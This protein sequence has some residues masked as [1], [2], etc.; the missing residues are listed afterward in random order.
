MLLQRLREALFRTFP[1]LVVV[2]RDAAALLCV[3]AAAAAAAAGGCAV[4]VATHWC[5]TP[6]NHSQPKF[7]SVF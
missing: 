6:Q 4:A 5:A 1:P 3:S 7:C 2:L